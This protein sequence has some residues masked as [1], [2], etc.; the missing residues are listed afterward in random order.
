[1]TVGNK[2]TNGAFRVAYMVMSSIR[3]IV[4]GRLLAASPHCQPAAS[5]C[6]VCEHPAG[7]QGE[8][9]TSRIALY[10]DLEMEYACSV[11]GVHFAAKHLN[12]P[13]L[14]CT[15]IRE[16]PDPHLFSFILKY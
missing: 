6:T 10:L 1:M 16:Y 13:V 5:V 3:S 2:D 15:G 12:H 7:S 4:I 11:F 9:V 8:G 14:I